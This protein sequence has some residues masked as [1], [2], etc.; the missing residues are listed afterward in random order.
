MGVDEAWDIDDELDFA[1]TD[2]LMQHRKKPK[3][4]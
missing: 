4:T 2:F 3:L 1:I